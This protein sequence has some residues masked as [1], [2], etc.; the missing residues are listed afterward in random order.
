MKI[1]FKTV[2]VA[3]DRKS[4]SKHVYVDALHVGTVTFRDD[5]SAA[6]SVNV[7]VNYVNHRYDCNTQREATERCIRAWLKAHAKAGEIKQPIKM[8]DWT[9]GAPRRSGEFYAVLRHLE[10]EVHL[11]N[12]ARDIHPSDMWFCGDFGSGYGGGLVPAESIRAHMPVPPE[13]E[14]PFK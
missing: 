14:S 2:S 4:R 7:S 13:P 3:S 12:R 10:K 9:S 6:G 8:G 1:S 5:G 11:I